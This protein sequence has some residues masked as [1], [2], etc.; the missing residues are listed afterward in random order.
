MARRVISFLEDRRVL[1]AEI[2]KEQPELCMTSVQDI[3]HFLT[4]TIQVMGRES[5]L[6]RSLRQMREAC[7]K[8]LDASSAYFGAGGNL[9]L[10][11]PTAMYNVDPASGHC[12]LLKVYDNSSVPDFWLA[13]GELREVVGREA[14][15]IAGRFSITAEPAFAAIFPNARPGREQS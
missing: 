13:L 12:E 8:F 10:G 5:E 9:S 4:E 3:R 6:K 2:D 1:F 14:G 11:L 15:W 7:R